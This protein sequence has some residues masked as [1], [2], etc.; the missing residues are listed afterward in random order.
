MKK[1][2]SYSIRIENYLLQKLHFVADYDGRSV[3]SEILF[4]IRKSIAEFEKENGK[5]GEEFLVN[6]RQY[7]DK[8]TDK[9]LVKK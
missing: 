6:C 9:V 8:K 7:N 1:I 4:F 2:R 5:I 3:N